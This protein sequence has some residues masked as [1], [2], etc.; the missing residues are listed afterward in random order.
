MKHLL[1]TADLDAAGISALLDLTDTMAEI[2]SRPVPKVPALRGRTVAQVFFEDSTRTRLSFDTAAKRLSADTLTFTASSSSLNKGESLRDTIETLSAMGVDAFVVRHRSSGVPLAVSNWTHASVI[3]AGDGW[4]QHPTQALLDAH[5]ITRSLGSGNSLSGV[6]VAIV[7]D[8]AHSRVARSD[9]DVFL[10]LGAQVTVV[11]PRTLV[12]RSWFG[13]VDVNV[14][15]SLDEMIGDVDVLYMLRLQKER[16]ASGLIPGGDEYSVRF[17]LD[18]R[19]AALLRTTALVLH[20]GP[21]N[22]GVEMVVDPACLPGSRIL[23]QVATGVSVRMAVLFSLLG[24][25]GEPVD[26]SVEAGGADR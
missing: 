7:G 24:H 3:N 18:D 4:H 19:R 25:S 10:K 20:P 2:G 26:A 6:H 5:T 9:V 21:M 1:T 23:V 15:E 22:R 11:A 17:G 14:T 8:V 13:R 12:P 16:M